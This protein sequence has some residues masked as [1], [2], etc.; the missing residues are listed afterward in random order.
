MEA[1]DQAELDRR[2]RI[3][4]NRISDERT[5]SLVGMLKDRRIENM[6]GPDQISLNI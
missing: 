6:I 5:A 3:E 2:E 4:A 1:A